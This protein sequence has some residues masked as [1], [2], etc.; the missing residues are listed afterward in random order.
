MIE[1]ESDV[2]TNSR[3]KRACDQVHE[4]F[5]VQ[6]EQKLLRLLSIRIPTYRK[7]R[8]VNIS[9]TFPNWNFMY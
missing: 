3:G 6:I 1:L 7:K 5:V 2:Y 9:S 8:D 4:F